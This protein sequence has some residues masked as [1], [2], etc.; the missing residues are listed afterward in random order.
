MLQI[1]VLE[2]G[3][4]VPPIGVNARHSDHGA[5][6]ASSRLVGHIGWRQSLELMS[7]EGCIVGLGANQIALSRAVRGLAGRPRLNP[8]A[9][10]SAKQL[11]LGSVFDQHDAQRV[12]AQALA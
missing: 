6:E 12:R 4:D 11:L 1:E 8:T 10:R 9:A 5:R 2:M 7:W 3:D